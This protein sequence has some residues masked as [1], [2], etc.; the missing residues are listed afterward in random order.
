MT[1]TNYKEQAAKLF[2]ELDENTLNDLIMDLNQ[3]FNEDEPI[4]NLDEWVDMMTEEHDSAIEML[5]TIQQSRENID[6]T[7]EYIRGGVYFYDYRTA[8]RVID[9]LDSHEDIIYLIQQGM[10]ALEDAPKYPYD[11]DDDTIKI[12]KQAI[13]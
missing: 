4:Y 13:K 2:K 11:L 9:L 12:L 5:Q 8:D 6:L 3:V 10:E 1:T 7:Q